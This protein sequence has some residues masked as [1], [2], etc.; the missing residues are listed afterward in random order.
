MRRRIGEWP[1]GI[2]RGV[3]FGDSTLM[4]ERLFKIAGEFEKRGERLV[5]RTHGSA[6]AIERAMNAQ[7]HMSKSLVG[8]A[9]MNFLFADL[10]RNA[11]FVSA[12]DFEFEPGSILSASRDFPTSLSMVE[13]ASTSAPSSTRRSPRRSSPTPASPR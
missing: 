6:P 3:H 1:D 8:N 12:I 10:P 11:G 2:Y 4:E 5:L 9:F 7:P 13:R